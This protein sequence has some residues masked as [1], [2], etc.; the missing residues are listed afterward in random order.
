MA[1]IPHWKYI[2]SAGIDLH[3]PLGAY[4]RVTHLGGTI[5]QSVRNMLYHNGINMIRVSS[6]ER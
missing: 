6:N 4:C 3:P 2:H 5:G 1:G